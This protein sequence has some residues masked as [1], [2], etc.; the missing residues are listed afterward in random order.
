MKER[1]IKF[2]DSMIDAILNDRKT[3]TRRIIKDQPDTT[4]AYLR[5]HQAW[6]EGLTLSQHLNNAWQSGFIN[7]DCPYGGVGD[8]LV[9]QQIGNSRIVLEITDVRIERAQDINEEQARAEGITDGGCTACGNHE[10]CGCDNPSPSAVDSF[11]WLWESIYGKG[12]WDDNPWVW[13]V[14]F[15]RVTP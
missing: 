2:I 4:E 7:V 13:V 6:V 5:E 11:A 8:C 14:E 9:V 15:K 10:P 12:S 3:V 1:P